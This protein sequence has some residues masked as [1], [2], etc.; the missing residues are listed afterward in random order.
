GTQYR[1]WD[2]DTSVTDEERAALDVPP[3]AE[4]H[5][6]AAEESATFPQPPLE[7]APEW[8][9]AALARWANEG[10]LPPQ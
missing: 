3:L 10:S 5:R 8:L 7:L 9:K 4:Q 6:R 2:T 1:V